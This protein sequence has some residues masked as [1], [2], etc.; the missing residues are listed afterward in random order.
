MAR[1]NSLAADPS[2]AVRLQSPGSSARPSPGACF[3][4]FCPVSVLPDPELL[5]KS[6]L[7]SSALLPRQP[8]PLAVCLPSMPPSPAHWESN[9]PLPPNPE[10]NRLDSANTC[11]CDTS[12]VLV[13]SLPPQ[14]ASG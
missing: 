12:P 2:P 13:Q 6:S 8:R 14:S 4:P 3:R 1:L 10:Q 5:A 9:C 7:R 11:T